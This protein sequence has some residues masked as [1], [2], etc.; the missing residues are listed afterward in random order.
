MI[1]VTRIQRHHSP[2]IVSCLFSG[3]HP[4]FFFSSSV[5]LT[6]ILSYLC[7]TPFLIDV[8]IAV[9]QVV[10][11]GGACL[12]YVLNVI[13]GHLQE[14]RKKCLS[15]CYHNNAVS[16]M[17]FSLYIGRWFIRYKCLKP[18]FQGVDLLGD[19]GISVGVHEIKSGV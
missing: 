12:K 13:Q 5:F 10:F 16:S 4:F 17:L 2:S 14:Y 6:P 11:I 3:C 15:Q 9:G 19:V 1:H 7:H 8:F 18:S